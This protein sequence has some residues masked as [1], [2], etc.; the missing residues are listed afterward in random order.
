MSEGPG[1]P[2]E[3]KA[4]G[5]E[6]SA[7]P[8]VD[9]PLPPALPGARD[10]RVPYASGAAVPPK[11]SPAVLPQ[12]ALP[13][14]APQPPAPA[15]PQ[16]GWQQQ[17]YP[18]LYPQPTPTWQGSAVVEPDWSALAQQHEARGRRRKRLWIVGSAL[19]V[20]IAAG[21]GVAVFMTGSGRS[22]HTVA[23]DTTASQQPSSSSSAS[24]PSSGSAS[25]S[26]GAHNQNVTSIAPDKGGIPVQLGSD[27]ATGTVP[28]FSGTALSLYGDDNSFGHTLVQPIDVSKSFT[29]SV[30]V[31]NQAASDS[32]AAVTEGSGAYYSFDIGRYDLG[33]RDAWNFKVQT[34]GGGT[35]D[36]MSKGPSTVGKWTLLTGSYNAPAH[37]MAFYVNGIA[38]A[39]AKIKGIA[40]SSGSLQV[41]RIIY[42]S[43]WGDSW[44]G[45]LSHIQ[46]WDQVLAPADIARTATG[47]TGASSVPPKWSWLS[48]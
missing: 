39:S 3:P 4:S 26:G 19:G 46:L 41:G 13:Q 25:P 30:W 47:P 16:P 40:P 48:G 6:S 18:Q 21:A 7:Q 42:D 43:K 14:P 27:V 33:G 34:I 36:L 20:L 31:L 8:T 5:T 2:D 29:V 15:L 38:Q 9:V 11:P 12:P 22:G 44:D 45:A 37:Q 32:R 17:Q 35:M 28:G 1:Q 10:P 23:S 24:A